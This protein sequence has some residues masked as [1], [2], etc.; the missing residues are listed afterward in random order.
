MARWQPVSILLI[1]GF[2]LYFYSFHTANPNHFGAASGDVSHDISPGRCDPPLDPDPSKWWVHPNSRITNL[3]PTKAHF[4]TRTITTACLRLTYRL[5]FFT[6]TKQ[7]VHHLSPITLKPACPKTKIHCDQPTCFRVQNI[8]NFGS[9]S[10]TPTG[11][12][13]I[14]QIIDSCPPGHAQ[15]YCKAYNKDPSK[16]VPP[17][18]R[19]ADGSTN[20]LDIDYHAY[21]NLTG[22]DFVENRVRVIIF[23]ILPR[24]NGLALMRD[25][26]TS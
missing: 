25:V 4:L 18:Q 11:I 21:K 24:M 7:R 13:I 14:V 10:N 23:G 22:T 16:I 15:N 1:N 20:Y 3:P 2:I 26:F 19:C 8:G 12:P 6:V 17:Q 5:T 9:S